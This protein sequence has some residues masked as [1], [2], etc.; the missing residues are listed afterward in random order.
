MGSSVSSTGVAVGSSVTTGID[1]GV[2]VGGGTGVVGVSGA[3]EHT[4]LRGVPKSV[5]NQYTR[6]HTGFESR[7]RS[8][9]AC[10]VTLWRII[11][12]L[13]YKFSPSI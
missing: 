4:S 3:A 6:R 2:S 5:Y 10:D 1:S 13:T 12:Y 7:K 11:L 8:E 9:D